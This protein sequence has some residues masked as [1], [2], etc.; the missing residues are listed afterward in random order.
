M[1]KVIIAIFSIL[2]LGLSVI[3]QDIIEKPQE[4][5]INYSIT[6]GSYF[7]KFND[8]NLLGFYT[9]PK[10]NYNLSQKTFIS[11]GL[12][13]TNSNI[14]FGNRSIN[15]NYFV[16]SASHKLNDKLT[17]T[18]STLLKIN[19]HS[20]INSENTF[21][22]NIKHYSLSFDY[23]IT[24]NLHLGAEIRT[25]NHSFYNSPFRENQLFFNNPW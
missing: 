20:L 17:I 10:I 19:N 11:A 3:A 23:K 24:E 9:M 6:A 18:G 25:S 14:N 13:L 1:I 5:K 21:N 12:M 2:T 22:N 16:L 8:N 15:N 7:T 4:A